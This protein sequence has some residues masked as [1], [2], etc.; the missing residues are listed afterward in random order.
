MREEARAFCG[1]ASDI[2]TPDK[3]R[4]SLLLLRYALGRLVRQQV[5]HGSYRGRGHFVLASP[6]II[7]P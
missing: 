1:Q 5:F 4:E 3:A 6:S 2:L 7:A